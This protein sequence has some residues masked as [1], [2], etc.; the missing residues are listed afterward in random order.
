VSKPYF[1]SFV[2]EAVRNPKYK[3]Y[4]AGR[5]EVYKEPGMYDI[6]EIRFFTKNLDEYFKFRKRWDLEEV[7]Q[8]ELDEIRGKV[9]KGFYEEV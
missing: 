1:L 8:T 5:I 9:K 2:E 7:S 4:V 6:E 3:G